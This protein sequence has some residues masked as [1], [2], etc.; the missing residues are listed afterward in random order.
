MPEDTTQAG[1]ALPPIL[2]MRDVQLFLRISRPA[3]YDL[4]HRPD[5]P[6]LKLG[7]NFRVPTQAFLGLG[8]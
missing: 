1:E 4:A 7:R 8:S 3:A 6:V 5:F 2:R